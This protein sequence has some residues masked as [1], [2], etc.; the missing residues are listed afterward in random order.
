MSK[1]QINKAQLF[2]LLILFY[3]LM[4]VI[5]HVTVLNSYH[6]ESG[7][8]TAGDAVIS[9][10]L[11]KKPVDSI[12]KLFQAEQNYIDRVNLAITD[13]PA[14]RSGYINVSVEHK[15]Q[16]IYNG[17]KPL[18]SINPNEWFPVHLGLHLKA[19]D[20][21]KLV[22]SSKD[23]KALPNL[24]LTAD[25]TTP[26]LTLTYKNDLSVLDKALVVAYCFII[27]SIIFLLI[28]KYRLVISWIERIFGNLDFYKWKVGPYAVVN[29]LVGALVLYA[30][31]FAIPDN[32]VFYLFEISLLLSGMWFENNLQIIKKKFF[33]STRNKII[34]ILLSLYTSFSIVGSKCFIYPINMHVSLTNVICFMAMSAVVFPLVVSL[35][36]VLGFCRETEKNA[37]MKGNMPWR[38]YLLCFGIIMFVGV[39]FIRAFNPAISTPDT[40]FCMN[41]AINSIFGVVNWHPPFYILWLKSIVRI[42]NSTYAVLLVHYAW[43]AFVFLEGM[44]FLY[45]R[46]MP[47]AAI[48]LVTLLTA[49]NCGNTVQLTTIWKDIPYTICALWTTILVARF[50]FEDQAHKWL[51]Y[52]E[53]V[54]AFICTAFMRANGIVVFVILIPVLLFYFRKNRKIWMACISSIVL[55]I[56]IVGPLYTYL[57]VKG[58]SGDGKF[59]GLGQDILAAYYNGGD[60]NDDAM[61]VVNAL[62]YNNIAEY[63][64]FPYQAPF[65]TGQLFGLKV[66]PFLKAYVSTFVRNPVLMTREIITRQDGVW[67]VFSP[68]DGGMGVVNYTGTEDHNPT[69]NG[70]APKRQFNFL[71]DRISEFT[72]QSASVPVL[73]IIEWRAGIWTLI[74]VLS[75]AVCVIFKNNPKFWILFAVQLGHILSLM[76]SLGWWDY[77][78]YWPLTLMS[79]F[80]ILLTL[81]IKKQEKNYIQ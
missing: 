31:K 66:I 25:G 13:L 37:L 15:D 45:R 77:R 43:F 71:T 1:G 14:D 4:W 53:F 24:Y 6:S 12:E 5:A 52:V 62:S 48:I 28:L 61:H 30:S 57:D 70:L 22:L 23:T 34:Y 36:Y 47:S 65:Y 42:W 2:T 21:Y 35:T 16:A 17:H 39:C 29:T 19:G 59:V 73:N 18:S 20:K 55:A 51:I 76:L 56:S 26:V 60:L 27:Y 46:G 79:L 78:Y 8:Y 80:L 40:V 33:A 11:P 7:E 41:Y 74:T 58:T 63:G 3:I 54:V 44:R 64:Y 32:T 72:A 75:F 81:T 9:E 69:W 10:N 67:N 38:V 68:Q 49:L 50:I